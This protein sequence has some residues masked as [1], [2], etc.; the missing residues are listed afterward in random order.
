M[1]NTPSTITAQIEDFAQNIYLN[2]ALVQ[3]N[4]VEDLMDICALEQLLQLA[5]LQGHTQPILEMGY[6]TGLNLREL[7][8]R[9]G[10]HIDMVEGSEALC[11]QARALYGE[12]IGVFC[13]FFEHFT[14]KKKYD[15][16]LA[17]HVLEHV[18]SPVQVLQQMRH[19]LSPH[20]RIIALVPNALS[21]HR[22]LAVHMGLQ[23]QLDTLSE[24]DHLV[25]H[26]RV[27]TPN[28]L[29]ASFTQAGFVIEQTFGFGIKLLPY[30]MMA[31]WS[32]E[33][34]RACVQISPDLPAELLG[35]IG[36]IAKLPD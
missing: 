26:Q 18:D 19:A 4:R 32:D 33:L 16:I 34:I 36:L 31:D 8:E 14:S 12:R 25:G 10:L 22:R 1:N 29:A 5:N 21:L 17:M 30:S 27:F 2:Q 20:G 15:H 11:A 7:V 13:S 28:S 3:N 24:R 35:N 23:E 9:H 6:G